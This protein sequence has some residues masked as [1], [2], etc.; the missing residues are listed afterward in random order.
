MVSNKAFD[1]VTLG[2]EASFTFLPES[3]SGAGGGGAD[4]TDVG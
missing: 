3:A 4:G 1:S 2:T